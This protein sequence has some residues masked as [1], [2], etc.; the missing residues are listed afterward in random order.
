M[1]IDTLDI[2]PGEGETKTITKTRYRVECEECGDPAHFKHS[3]LLAGDCRANPASSA[4]GR[5]DCT[6]CS[7]HEAFTCKTCKMP[8][9]DGYS[10]CSTFP[11]TARFAHMF[12]HWSEREVKVC[13][14]E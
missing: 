1:E 11:A 3:Y 4:Y 9:V 7:D 8:T 12:L 2:L 5:D 13:S 10:W 14:P 6:W